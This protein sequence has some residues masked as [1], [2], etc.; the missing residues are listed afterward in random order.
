MDL[1][2]SANNP[3]SGTQT[4]GT[5]F[6]GQF[7]DHDM[8]FD[9]TSRRARRRTRPPR[10]TPARRP[11]I[12]TL[13]MAADHR[14]TPSSMSKSGGGQIPTGNQF[15]VES[16]GHSKTCLAKAIPQLLRTRAT[17][18]TWSSLASRLRFFS[19]TTKP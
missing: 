8:T 14:R 17:M 10:P 11:L 9:L 5:M 7:M 15:E 12:S 4:A 16:G 18:R 2:L 3:N 19:F 1:T 6:M 13:F